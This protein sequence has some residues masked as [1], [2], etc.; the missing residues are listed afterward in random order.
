MTLSRSEF[1]SR[2]SQY[3]ERAEPY[4]KWIFRWSVIG[5]VILAVVMAVLII[6]AA[7]RHWPFN[8]VM[9]TAG[10]LALVFPFA[11]ILV[12]RKS[13][14]CRR[15]QQ[16]LGL[17]C[18]HC[19]KGLVGE[20]AQ[21]TYATG[22]CPACDAVVLRAD[23]DSERGGFVTY[24]ELRDKVREL[25]SVWISIL[26]PSLA[27]ILVAL[28]IAGYVL[29]APQPLK[30]LWA[31]PATLVPAYLI[32]EYCTRWWRRILQERKLVCPHCGEWL[33]TLGG[34]IA[35]KTGACEKCGERILRDETTPRS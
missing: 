18:D 30:L 22:K 35:V 5:G 8:A 9:Y 2:Q 11:A 31:I 20:S 17:L 26:A 4:S 16:E 23:E 33:I 28:G 24:R 10:A 34:D 21:I 27:S 3:I 6:T 29:N 19:R 12:H 25:R 1:A 15:L 32:I 14:H 7:E 13:R